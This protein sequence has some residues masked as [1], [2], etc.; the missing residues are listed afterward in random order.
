MQIELATAIQR[1]MWFLD[2]TRAEITSIFVVR[3]SKSGN[4]IETDYGAILRVNSK[5]HAI[6]YHQEMAQIARKLLL[7]EHD[8]EYEELL[9]RNKLRRV[10]R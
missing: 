8:A 1:K 2:K 4:T 9:K 6:F 3:E 7:K 5:R 10:Q